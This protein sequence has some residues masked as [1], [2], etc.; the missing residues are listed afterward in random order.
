MSPENCSHFIGKRKQKRKTPRQKRKQ[1]R[2][3]GIAYVGHTCFHID[4]VLIFFIFVTF[5]VCF[6]YLN[7][8][9]FHNQ[10]KHH[11]HDSKPVVWILMC[12]LRVF[13]LPLAKQWFSLGFVW[14]LFNVRKT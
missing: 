14:A 11:V 4:F 8:V 3:P 10:Q 5:L 2:K 1:K 12:F 13:T 7:G 6:R 9:E